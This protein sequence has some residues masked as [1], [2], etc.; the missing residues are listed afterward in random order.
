[1]G[2][3]FGDIVTLSSHP[4]ILVQGRLSITQNV[5]REKVIPAEKTRIN[6]MRAFKMDQLHGKIIL[7]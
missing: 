6:E 5:G 1:M 4:G 7:C 3:A 2:R